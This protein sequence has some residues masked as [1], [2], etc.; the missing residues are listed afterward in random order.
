[1]KETFT[2]KYALIPLVKELLIISSTKI[3]MSLCK[4]I[5]NTKE[6]LNNYIDIAFV[7]LLKTPFR[8]FFGA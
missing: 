3:A 7:H 4:K 2:C 1:M 5:I 8:S 6:I